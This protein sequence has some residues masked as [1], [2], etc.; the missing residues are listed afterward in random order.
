MDDEAAAPACLRAGSAPGVSGEGQLPRLTADEARSRI[1][2][3]LR[4][5]GAPTLLAPSTEQLAKACDALACAGV[6]LGLARDALDFL[7]TCTDWL[8]TIAGIEL[9]DEDPD[10]QLELLR[11]VCGALRASRQLLQAQR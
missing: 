2:A 10:R 8:N 3:D 7:H 1:A 5:W 11:R 4:R 6:H 9:A